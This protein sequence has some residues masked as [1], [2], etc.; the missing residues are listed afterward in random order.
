MK[1]R[2]KLWMIQQRMWSNGRYTKWKWDYAFV[3]TARHIV[4]YDFLQHHNDHCGNST[5][6]SLKDTVRAACFMVDLP[7]IK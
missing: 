2:R 1:Q 5:M 3:G 4:E 7:E 6:E